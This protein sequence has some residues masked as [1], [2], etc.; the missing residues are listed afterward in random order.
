M[1]SVTRRKFAL[2]TGAGLLSACSP[3]R[4]PALGRR[5]A[6]DVIIIGAGLSG[7]HA[8]RML[9][10]EGLKVLVLE[11]AGRPGGRMLT[12]DDVPGQPE[13][14][15]Q[16]VGQTYARIRSTARDLGVGIQPYPERLRG[17]ALA[18]G[19][20]VL[21]LSEWAG[22]PE[23]PFPEA[24]RPLTPS[25]ALLVAAGRAN[26]L[27]DNYAW[28]EIMPES[29]GPADA[30]LEQ[31]GFGAEARRLIDISV[32]ANRL[33]TY[34]IVNVWRSLTLFAEDSAIGPSERVAGGSSRLTEAMAASLPGNALRLGARV[35]RI[36][37]RGTHGEVALEGGE[38]LTAP[39]VICSLP[40]SAMR[41]QVELVPAE[42]DPAAALRAEAIDGLPYTQI[43]QVHLEPLNRFWEADGLAA[44]MWTDTAI[45]R[46]FTNFDES[47]EIASLTCWI[48]GDGVQASRSD[49]DWFDL[50][51]RTLEALRGAKVRGLKVTRWDEAQPLNGGAY[52]HWAPG[53]IGRWAGKMGAP[54]GHVH[55]AGEHLS[56]LHTGME[57]AMESGEQAAYAVM[58][59]LRPV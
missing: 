11:A 47:G 38:T 43:Q 35:R 42:G 12:L 29:D 31:A 10:D 25:A 40:F 15:G 45:E 8:A 55:F 1:A 32:N 30:F 19:G 9:A 51:A 13:A 56:F 53:Q 39:A 46:V 54:S 24:Y 48:N 6:A 58:E 52:M 14:G 3:A 22:A 27:A 26:P 34:S 37:D 5:D 2:M 21:A 33:S 7:L 23:N 28:R 4:A 59:A 16:Q 50:A 18:V 57:G 41:G 49:A 44:D 36:A 17:T 20:R